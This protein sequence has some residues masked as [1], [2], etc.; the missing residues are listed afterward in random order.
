[1]IIQMIG[2]LIIWNT[3]TAVSLVALFLDTGL[4]A[5]L[6]ALTPL[7]LTISFHVF[8]NSNVK[9]SNKK[10]FFA[11][12]KLGGHRGS[13][14]EA[15]ENSVESFKKAKEAGCEVVEF[16]IHLSSDGIPVLIHDDT[17]QRTS[18]ENVTIAET[19]FD[20]IKHIP[21]N[22]VKGISAGIPTLE[23]T[24]DW[25]QQNKM[26]MIF[27][28]KC[29]E[30][31]MIEALTHLIKTKN[32]YDSVIISSF[33]AMVPYLIKR[34][35]SKILTGFT[36]RVDNYVYY[37]DDRTMT[38]TSTTEYYLYSILDDLIELGIR[39]FVLPVFL[40]VDMLL[41]HYKNINGY[42][43]DD[44]LSFGIHVVAWTVNDQE[45]A[46]FLRSMKVPILSDQP[47]NLN[48]N[49]QTTQV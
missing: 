38:Y 3:L 5:K 28:V 4:C 2:C 21:L 12:F 1:M 44:S 31:R 41:L 26:R 8:K 39:L 6:I 24:V 27:D 36:S 15:P 30:K 45:T 40:G 20:E 10:T 49:K 46:N 13:P 23:E 29:A 18:R 37:D 9:E 25:C 11:N 48:D 43:V 33:D 17:T 32:L 19:T 47:Q 22:E 7:T 34:I 16:D 14:L 35:D 42:L